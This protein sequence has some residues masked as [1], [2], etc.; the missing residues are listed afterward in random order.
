MGGLTRN[1]PWDDQ[2]PGGWLRKHLFSIKTLSLIVLSVQTSTMVLLL[3]YSRTAPTSNQTPYIITTA[4]LLSEILKL[5]LSLGFLH[6]ETG[7]V[8]RVTLHRLYRDVL[9]NVWET[10]KLAV[11]ACLYVVQ[12]NLLFIALSNLDAATYQVTYQL[13]ILTTA[14]F[15]WV[16]L[17]K[18][19]SPI[20]WLS[21]CFLMLGV[22]LVQVD[23][24]SSSTSPNKILPE[25]EVVEGGDPMIL[26][27]SED[28]AGFP[29]PDIHNEAHPNTEVSWLLGIFAVFISC[30]SSGFSGVYFERL[31]KRGKQPSLIIRNIQLGMFSIIFAII[32]VSS[33]GAAIRE[34]GFFQGYTLTTWGVVLIQ[35]FGGLMVSVTM[36]YADNILKGFATSL[37]IVMST[38][39]SWLVLGDAAPST[40]F[41][42]GAS[43]VIASTV[44]YGL[45]P[46]ASKGINQGNQQPRTDSPHKVTGNKKSK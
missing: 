9:L 40:Q 32:A 42:F 27:G 20:H 12:N 1:T 7:K 37:S 17:G 25:V 14:I 21:L 3:R 24:G 38:L 26:G 29:P 35:A 22:S 46:Q 39:V 43:I 4:V 6:I 16:I 34:G 31:V 8:L 11:P 18:H 5:G 45:T 44:L 30:I 28:G 13:K 19:L 36:K 23:T 41:V 10:L 33:D 2:A 15:S